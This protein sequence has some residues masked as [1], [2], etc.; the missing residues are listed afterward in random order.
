MRRWAI[1]SWWAAASIREMKIPNP[2][3]APKLIPLYR[4]TMGHFQLVLR[5]SLTMME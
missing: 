1:R 5:I 4:D 3:R 2:R